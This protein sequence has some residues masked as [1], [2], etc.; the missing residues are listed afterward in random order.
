MKTETYLKPDC[1]IPC[2]W[3]EQILCSSDLT[4]STESYDD[5]TDYNW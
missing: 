4:G 1:A 2:A 3:L 5:L